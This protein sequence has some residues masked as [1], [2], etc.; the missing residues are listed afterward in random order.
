[1]IIYLFYHG[2]FEQ[3]KLELSLILPE[4]DILLKTFR[5][6]HSYY[7]IN[8]NGYN[9]LF[10]DSQH[11]LGLSI[12]PNNR[13]S[14]L[15]YKQTEAY[16][17]KISERLTSFTN[18]TKSP[19]DNIL[20]EQYDF[21]GKRKNSDPQISYKKLIP[22]ISSPVP[23]NKT[24]SQKISSEDKKQGGGI[25]ERLLSP[26]V[27]PLLN[28]IGGNAPSSP[29][30]KTRSV[31]ENLAIVE[32]KALNFEKTSRELPT[33][34]PAQ[35]KEIVNETEEKEDKNKNNDLSSN[36]NNEN[37]KDENNNN[38]NNKD[39]NNRSDNKDNVN[40]NNKNDNDQDEEDEREVDEK[41]QEGNEELKHL[42]ENEQP[43]SSSEDNSSS[44][45]S[46][47]SSSSSSSNSSSSSSSQ[48][49]DSQE[50]IEKKEEKNQEMSITILT[51][52]K[53]T[54]DGNE[55]KTRNENNASQENKEHS[56]DEKLILKIMTE[57]SQIK[58]NLARIEQEKYDMMKR[59]SEL[60]EEK[61]EMK[62]RIF[63]LENENKS[64]FQMIQMMNKGEI[65]AAQ[66]INTYSRGSDYVY[67]PTSLTRDSSFTSRRNEKGR[68][69]SN[70]N[71]EGKKGPTYT[72]SSSSDT[73]SN[74][75]SSSVSNS[76]FP[77]S[78]TVSSAFSS[79]SSSDNPP[80]DPELPK[81][82]KLP[83]MKN[84]E[85]KARGRNEK[86]SE[87]FS[88]RKEENRSVAIYGMPFL[89]GQ[90]SSDFIY[91]QFADSKLITQ[92]M[93]INKISSIKPRSGKLPFY[94]IEFK[95]QQD[96]KTILEKK[97]TLLSK[98]KLYVKPWIHRAKFYSQPRYH[99]Q[100]RNAR[101]SRYSYA[102]QDYPSN[103]SQYNSPEH[104]YPTSNSSQHNSRENIYPNLH[105]Q[106]PPQFHGYYPPPPP[107]SSYYPG[108]RFPPY[109]WGF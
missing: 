76:Y 6:S 47:G 94:I 52:E 79:S 107:L 73:F 80:I 7:I 83:E 18:F 109:P 29:E 16:V 66:P 21:S 60:E 14:G 104:L 65:K 15:N 67:A 57:I 44:S 20:C 30:S 98:S 51:P 91:K 108:N 70:S 99:L 23:D 37:N 61:V 81:L 42:K 13:R 84:S 106:Y 43:T 19:C 77:N 38:E 53:E 39:E 88:T 25:I 34:V 36:N 3:L 33:N 41:N 9:L 49:K 24:K 90:I 27:N 50:N 22:E 68:S 93:P 10:K 1:M 92:D 97:S 82:S 26:I 95:N 74:S 45:N 86:E 103:S 100:Q 89:E 35:S 58:G 28:L 71:S 11:S 12:H 32:T 17:Y 72:S 31:V 59:V 55:Q 105:T 64:L 62:N 54:P 46:S 96:V 8:L 85:S 48:N 40:N 75:S 87:F 4:E 101:E 102:R 56:N 5:K 69:R 78:F 2:T 63:Q